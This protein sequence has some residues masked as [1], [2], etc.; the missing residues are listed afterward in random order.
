[1]KELSKSIPG[2]VNNPLGI[3]PEGNSEHGGRHERTLQ[4]GERLNPPTELKYFTIL[5]YCQACNGR[6]SPP[7]YATLQPRLSPL[8]QSV[9]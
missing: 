8:R 1:M 6:A 3:H 5:C 2:R 9:G 4:E 7:V